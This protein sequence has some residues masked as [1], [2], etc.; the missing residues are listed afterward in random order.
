MLGRCCIETWSKTQGSIAQSSAESELLA[1]VR[2]A[3]EGLGLISLS[4]VM[5]LVFKV[6]LHID[7]A[8]AL[9]IIERRVVGR[10]R[11][12]DVRALWL[13]EQQLGKVIELRKVAG[14]ENPSDLLTKHLTDERI[15][16]YSDFIG[17]TFV[18]RQA[19]AH[20]RVALHHRMRFLL[21]LC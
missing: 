3:A 16:H 4:A 12:L 2:S 17:Y 13:R 20:V 8:A 19:V 1:T 14:L 6:R 10:V 18:K 7:A 15:S 5:G 9:G 11:H 21:C